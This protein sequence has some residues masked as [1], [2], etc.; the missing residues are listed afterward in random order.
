MYFAMR[1]EPPSMYY[2]TIQVA[3]E[4]VTFYLVS[5]PTSAHRSLNLHAGG[6]HGESLATFG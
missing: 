5:F 1:C 4:N 3:S 2:Q 6:F